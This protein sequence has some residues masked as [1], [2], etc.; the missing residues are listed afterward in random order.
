MDIYNEKAL[1][2]EKFLIENFL[3]C[4]LNI[5]KL[6]ECIVKTSNKQNIRYFMNICKREMRIQL[7]QDR[8]ARKIQKI[9][10]QKIKRNH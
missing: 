7:E 10:K 1:E 3:E 8:S 6:Y 9:C 2:D 5:V 4:N